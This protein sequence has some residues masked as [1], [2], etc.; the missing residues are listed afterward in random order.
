MEAKLDANI[1]A[2]DYLVNHLR[3]PSGI[4]ASS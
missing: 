4:V 3:D 1:R 2:T